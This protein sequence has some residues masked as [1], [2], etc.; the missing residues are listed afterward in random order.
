MENKTYQKYIATSLRTYKV[1]IF[2]IERY[3]GFKEYTIK[4]DMIMEYDLE[5]EKIS[6]PRHIHELDRCGYGKNKVLTRIEEEVRNTICYI[7]DWK[8]INK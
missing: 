1:K 7:E 4:F 3:E 8:V 5:G 6:Y 2:N